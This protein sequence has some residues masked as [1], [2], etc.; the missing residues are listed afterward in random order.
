M[1]VGTIDCV[2]LNAFAPDHAPDAVHEDALVDDHVSVVGWPRE[3]IAL[4]L[5]EMVTVGARDATVATIEAV[6]GND[7]F[8][9]KRA[10]KRDPMSDAVMAKKVRIPLIDYWLLTPLMSIQYDIL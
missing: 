1:L 6:S 5:A 3:V 4:G 10:P 2:P 8:T 7:V 9:V